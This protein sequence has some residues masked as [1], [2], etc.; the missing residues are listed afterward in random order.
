MCVGGVGHWK[1]GTRS[2]LTTHKSQFTTPDDGLNSTL[3]S[4]QPLNNSQSSTST[5]KTILP[6]Y[7]KIQA[8]QK[9]NY[10]VLFHPAPRSVAYKESSHPHS[11]IFQ[12]Q[13][14]W[15]KYL[16]PLQTPTPE[17][18]FYQEKSPLSPVKVIKTGQENRTTQHGKAL[19]RKYI[20]CLPFRQ[21]IIVS[22]Y[23]N[24]ITLQITVYG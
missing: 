20:F 5:S 19:P 6:V 13:F 11:F 22:C 18:F 2:I 17:L 14:F 7:Y 15:G 9:R 23:L 24:L 1:G 4:T 8:S 16:S 12:L 3:N 21:Q 10:I